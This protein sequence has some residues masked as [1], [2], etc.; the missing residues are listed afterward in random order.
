M[1]KRRNAA[2]DGLED[3]IRDHLERE[4]EINIAR[5]MSPEEARRQARLAF[6]NVALVQEDA[7][8]AWTWAW[9]EQARQDLRFGAR[10]LKNSPGLSF[11][12]AALIALV[13]GINT[14]IFSMV[15]ALVTRPAPGV[16]PDGLVRIAIAN[17][18]GA[19]FVSYPDYL[20]YAA[21]TTSL[22]SLTAFT[23]GRVTV[24]SD[25]GSYALMAA[26]V[27][28]KFFDAVGIR[29]VRGR[30][31]T[32]SE[33]R[34]TD[35]AALVAI[36]S[37]RA[38]QDLFGGTED[39]V[40]RAIAV[41]NQPATVIGVAPP[42]FR[43]TMAGERDDVWLPLLMYWSSF[44]PD[45][46]QRWLTDRSETPV[47]LIGR[48]APGKSLAAAQAD[49]ATM[50]A[51]LNRAYPVADRPLI[52]VVRYAA[53]AGGVIPAGAPVFLAIF[54][55]V[56]LLTVLIVSANVANLM[57]S[58]AVARQ[59]ETAVRQSLGASRFR[60]VRL[61][62]AE[63]LSISVVA[64]LAACLM[65]VWAAR[66][67][68]R[69][70]PES[71]FAE[72]GLDF[73]PD[74]KVVAYAMALAAIG[75]VAFS[76]AP[77]LRVWRQDALPWLKAGEHSVASGR[78]RLSNALVVLQLGFSVV[79]LTLAGLATRS[80]SLMIVD[81]GFNSDNLLL[82]TARTT[83]GATTRE[84][85]LVLIDRIRERLRTI[86]GVQ[87][88]SYVRTLPPFAW[89]TEMVRT[90][91]VPEG[92]RAT[93]HVVGPDYFPTMGLSPKAGRT[94]DAADRDRPDAMAVINQN[95]A[96]ALWPGQNPLG[97]TMTLRALGFRGPSDVETDRVE[98]VGVAPNAFVAGFNPERPNP[99]PNL[100]FI[101]EQRAFAEGRGDPA[102]PGEITFYLRHGG[103]DLESVA[104]AL[105][106]VL[107]DVEPRVAIVSTRTM[108]AQLEGVTFL[109][110]ILARLLLI[111]SLISLL[112]AAIGQ[113]AVIAFNMQRRV[114]EFGVRMALGASA[115][116]ILAS[117][118]GE[119][120]ALTAI[121]LVA[122]LLLSLAVAIAARGALFG[123]TPTDARTYGGV[124]A[125]LGL[126][127]LIACCVPARA[128]TRV[129]PVR[130]LRQE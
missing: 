67:I 128:A 95:L 75:T 122:G 94:L 54:S 92:V 13:I 113:Y 112:V 21:Q 102:A 48:L 35:A 22:R 70:L 58:R 16:S 39:I 59:R 129:D 81:L 38:W 80:A 116:Q 91:G 106:P 40:G 42:N 78:S 5:G 63:G 41:N 1:W 108:D 46:Q 119:G 4:T 88:V 130:A 3:E 114:R 11:T 68:P 47:D 60:I 19:P 10:I 62:L 79:L 23:N 121:G 86:P 72:S 25:S 93:L 7:R 118:L 83:G 115:R 28:A 43:G 9:F 84:T 99:R 8:A 126:V 24:T 90:A 124:F 120:F 17:R 2:L 34:S 52:A 26:A 20:D 61:L 37:Y 44:P 96:E 87:Q 97:K 45:V 117:V 111:F 101:A 57:L 64:W 65:T 53:T 14:T 6:G 107:R 127:A 56:T 55:I 105:G 27:D 31:F 74:W 76:L 109:A 123:V 82:L 125:L 29:P 71:P 33:G 103:S 30:T 89:S 110:R 100:V 12:A 50:Q 18:P 104:S 85:N 51:R 49:F 66:A 69:L 73:S 32:P 36:V 98:V 77:A 15:N